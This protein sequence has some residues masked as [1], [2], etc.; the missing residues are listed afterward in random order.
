MAALWRYGEEMYQ[1]T[2]TLLSGP[3][4]PLG[5]QTRKIRMQVALDRGGNPD[6][7]RWHDDPEPW[8]AWL[9]APDIVDRMGDVQYEA[10]LGWYLRMPPVDHGPEDANSWAINFPHTPA[11]PGETMV[12]RGPD[13]ANWA[14]RIVQVE[15]QQPALS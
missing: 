9:E 5:D 2:M 6:P 4:F 13:G 7:Q 12:T 1:L 14:W 10:D 3:G 15:A 11:R 8:R